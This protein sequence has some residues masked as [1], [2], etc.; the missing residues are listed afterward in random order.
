MHSRQHQMTR[1]NVSS[2]H[3]TN[4]KRSV[5]GEEERCSMKFLDP[6]SNILMSRILIVIMGTIICSA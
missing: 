1:P 6:T 2:H 3:G 5:L 4:T